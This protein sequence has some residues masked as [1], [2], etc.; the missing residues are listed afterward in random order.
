[1]K[2]G[3]FYGVSSA[4]NLIVPPSTEKIPQSTINCRRPVSVNL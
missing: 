1:M 4:V 3:K 2:Q